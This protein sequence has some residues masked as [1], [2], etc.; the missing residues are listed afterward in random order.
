MS[1]STTFIGLD[2]HK[3][4]IVAA[5]L[6]PRR[7]EPEIIKLANTEQSLRR[8][9]R[10]L[11]KTTKSELRACYEAGPL[12]FGLLRQLE[13]LEVDACVIA[14]SKIPSKPGDRVKTDR[15]DAEKLAELLRAD[16]LTEVHPPNEEDEAVRDLCRA[17][18]QAKAS[19]TAAKHRLNKFLTR[20][21][22]RY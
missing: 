2:A 15:R 9:V 13:A 11:R 1:T 20:R 4:T 7:K 8:F 16:L 22:K 18:E 14:P 17:R 10:K 6:Y 12:G 3:E 21:N 19:Q 5:V